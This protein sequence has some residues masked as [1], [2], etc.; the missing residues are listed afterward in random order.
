MHIIMGTLLKYSAADKLG[1][2]TVTNGEVP[3]GRKKTHR[4]RTGLVS[5]LVKNRG[6]CFSLDRLGQE[7]VAVSDSR[8]LGWEVLAILNTVNTNT[9]TVTSTIVIHV[10]GDRHILGLSCFR[11]SFGTRGCCFFHRFKRFIIKYN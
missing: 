2:E 9:N 7:G 5:I 8:L 3:K 4:V 1:S 6:K 11:R 10:V